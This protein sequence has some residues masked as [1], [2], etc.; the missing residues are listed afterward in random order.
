[1]AKYQTWHVWLQMQPDDLGSAAHWGLYITEAP[2]RF[3]AAANAATW[4]GNM[5]YTPLK[6]HAYDMGFTS[7]K[8]EPLNIIPKRIFEVE[9]PAPSK[10]KDTN[11]WIKT[12]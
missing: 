2:D 9:R 7:T 5:G 8:S 11:T 3:E 1:M 10:D 4:A 12:S 6:A